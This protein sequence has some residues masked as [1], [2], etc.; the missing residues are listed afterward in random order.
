MKPNPEKLLKN[1]IR[2]REKKLIREKKMKILFE[3]LRE[4]NAPPI[5]P[6]QVEHL[7]AI[8]AE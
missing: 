8:S 5:E 7:K 4:R 2:K 1:R 6:D 3:D